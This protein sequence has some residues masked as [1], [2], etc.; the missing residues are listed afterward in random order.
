MTIDTLDPVFSFLY[1]TEQGDP[2]YQGSDSSVALLWDGSDDLSGIR[3][4]RSL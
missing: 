1:E 3:D 4:M 2:A